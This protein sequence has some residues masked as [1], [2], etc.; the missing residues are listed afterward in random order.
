[1]IYLSGQ[2]VVFLMELLILDVSEEGELCL[3]H[4]CVASVGEPKQSRNPQ[5]LAVQIALVNFWN[6]SDLLDKRPFEHQPATTTVEP[7][8]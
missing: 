3:R 5:S 4:S 7:T 1:M 2:M 6:A 8:R